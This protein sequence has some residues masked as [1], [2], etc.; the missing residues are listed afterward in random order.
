MEVRSW[1]MVFK[2]P[3]Q[4]AGTTPEETLW[5]VLGEKPQAHSDAFVFPRGSTTEIDV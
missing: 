2:I 5:S 4:V 1:E 3:E